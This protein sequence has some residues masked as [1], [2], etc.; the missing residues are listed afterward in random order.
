MITELNHLGAFTADLPATEKFYSDLF[1]A[2]VA[3]RGSV[4]AIG[5][6]IAYLQVAAGLVEFLTFHDPAKNTARGT[7]H[8]GFITDD[9]DADHALLVESGYESAVAPR[10]A[11][12]GVGRQAFLLESNGVR[13]ELIERDLPL[14]PTVVEHPIVKAIDHLSLR[15]DDIAKS[16]DFFHDRLGIPFLKDPAM[17]SGGTI[18]YLRLGDDTLELQG[19]DT[20]ERL[21]H[22]A[23]RVDD[24]DAALG[25][26]VKAGYEPDG[27]SRPAS[28]GG[29][30][31]SITDPN[32]VLITVLD[33][34]ALPDL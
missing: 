31:G 22:I 32:G 20:G 18:A 9:L 25:S 34:P 13:I 7:D 8:L 15:T 26:F 10:V 19:A 17:A 21:H 16:L 23:L 11:G 1:G 3:W 24:V 14:R 29:R 30:L 27:P 4:D 28:S 5:M 33:R 2:R 12:S 6:E